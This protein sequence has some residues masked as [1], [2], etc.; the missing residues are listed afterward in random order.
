MPLSVLNLGSIV[1]VGDVDL[2]GLK[3]FEKLFD[4]S[5]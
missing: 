1:S 3:V 5:N 2:S 4:G